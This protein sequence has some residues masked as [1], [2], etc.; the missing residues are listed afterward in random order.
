MDKNTLIGL[1]LIG[2]ILSVFTIYN[3]PSDQNELGVKDKV[4]SI[5]KVS[6]TDTIPEKIIAN[7]IEKDTII[8][9]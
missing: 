1:I 8:I 7:V 2:L 6:D 5:E 3:K 4:S 9:R